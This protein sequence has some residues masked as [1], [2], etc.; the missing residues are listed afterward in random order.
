MITE[1]AALGG[2][3]E[4]SGDV[5]P[6]DDL[7]QQGIQRVRV[8]SQSQL[9]EV[10][11]VAVNRAVR[12]QLGDLDLPVP[13][14]ERL[15]DAT[16]LEYA[17]LLVEGLEHPVESATPPPPPPPRRVAPPPPPAAPT[18]PA[19]AAPQAEVAP[20]Q[21][22]AQDLEGLE[23]RMAQNISNLL[24]K[25]W[26]SDLQQVQ[27]SQ[28]SQLQLLEQRIAKLVGALE[29]TDRLVSQIQ[30]SRPADAAPGTPDSDGAG[31]DPESP[32]YERKSE[33]LSAL[34]QANMEL[35]ELQGR[36]DT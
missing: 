28:H 11:R 7:Q 4:E 34:F 13:V 3:F 10:L 20:P 17:R 14:L 29:S 21:P 26:R 18:A 15:R 8:L 16:E 31:P 25:D 9:G 24:Q 33:L 35:R 1:N 36:E 30:E 5:R 22:P 12:R 19:P 23:E 2:A 27:E 32:L 6:I